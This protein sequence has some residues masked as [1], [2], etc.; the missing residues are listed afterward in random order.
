MLQWKVLE[1]SGQEL[2]CP[3]A[4]PGALAAREGAGDTFSSHGSLRCAANSRM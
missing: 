4:S 3:G 2:G 1:E